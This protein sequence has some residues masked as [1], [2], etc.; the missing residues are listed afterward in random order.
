VAQDSGIKVHLDGKAYPLDDFSLGDLEWLEEY[1]GTTLD[2]DRAL[3]S[4]KA[5]V[6]FAFL[7]KRMDDPE[8]TIEQARQL[9]LGVL[10]QSEEN[11]NGKPKA[12]RPPK[13]AAAA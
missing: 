1:L 13:R 4:M 8:F 9:K 12:K 7:I 3:S 11:G 2:D 6:G 10:E 5:A